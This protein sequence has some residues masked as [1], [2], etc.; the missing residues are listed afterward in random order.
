MSAIWVVRLAAV[1]SLHNDFG[2]AVPI[3]LFRRARRLRKIGLPRGRAY[4]CQGCVA[5]DH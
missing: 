2:A 4:I 1:L 3:P 5:E